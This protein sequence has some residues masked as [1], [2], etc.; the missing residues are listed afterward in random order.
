M[1]RHAASVVVLLV[2]LAGLPGCGSG[3][4]EGPARATD[5]VTE[6]QILVW[7]E[8]SRPNRFGRVVGERRT[9]IGKAKSWTLRCDPPGGTFPDPEAAC[10]RLDG[11]DQPFA[12][13]P[14]EAICTEQY[15]G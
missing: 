3:E 11:L 12:D 8:G 5:T 4:G 15:G 14:E 7:P 2:V 10:N 6:L 13:T 1:K 9:P